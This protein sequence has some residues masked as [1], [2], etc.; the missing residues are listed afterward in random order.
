MLR[1]YWAVV[2][3]RH[4]L[5]EVFWM[6]NANPFVGSFMCSYVCRRLRARNK[7][8]HSVKKDSHSV[9]KNSHSVNKDDQATRDWDAKANDLLKALK[10]T[11]K[12]SQDS[13]AHRQNERIGCPGNI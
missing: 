7:D 5:A 3:G 8:S 9:N 10:M 13:L 11:T 12:K 4:R 6:Q 2:T 1:L